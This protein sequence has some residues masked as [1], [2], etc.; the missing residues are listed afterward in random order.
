MYIHRSCTRHRVASHHA[1]HHTC[2][3]YRWLRPHHIWSGTWTHRDTSEEVML[4]SIFIWR[5]EAHAWRQIAHILVISISRR[6]GCH[7]KPNSSLNIT[8]EHFSPDTGSRDLCGRSARERRGSS[9]LLRGRFVI[10]LCCWCDSTGLYRHYPG[11]WLCSWWI[12]PCDVAS[13]SESRWPHHIHGWPSRS[14]RGLHAC[15][16]WPL[17]QPLHPY[18]WTSGMH[19]I[20]WR[21]CSCVGYRLL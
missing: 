6:I 12:L 9:C 11:S 17:F 15:R 2:L 1:P 10:W 13:D 20:W 18:L 3:C 19:G 7:G 16:L 8:V 14:Y 4:P 5:E 21:H